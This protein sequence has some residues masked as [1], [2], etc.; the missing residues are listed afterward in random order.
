MFYM[1]YLSFSGT[2]FIS[3]IK[4]GIIFAFRGIVVINPEWN[5]VSQ[6]RNGRSERC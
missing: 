5:D 1:N 6:N 3:I 4:L 2:S